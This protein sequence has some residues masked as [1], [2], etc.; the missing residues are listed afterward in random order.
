MQLGVG[1]VHKASIGVDG[2]GTNNTDYVYAGCAGA[3]VPTYTRLA[4]TAIGDGSLLAAADGG[5]FRMTFNVPLSALASCGI[6]ATT[7]MAPFVGTSQAGP[8]ENINKDFF[9]GNSVSFAAVNTPPVAVDDT[10]AATGGGAAAPVSVLVNDSD[11]DGDPLVVTAVDTTGTVGSVS[12][13]TDSKSVSYTPPAVV[14]AG[15]TTTFTYTISD[16]NGGSDVATVTVTLSANGEVNTPPVAVDD[17][18]TTG[19]GSPVAINVLLNDSD[20]DG[21]AL[22][23][24]GLTGPLHGSLSAIGGVVTYTPDAGFS[25]TD[26]F[27]YQLS[28]GKG[29]T[30]TAT[31]TVLAPLVVEAP[32]PPVSPSPSVSPTTEPTQE[33]TEQP[34]TEPTVDP[35]PIGGVTSP[36]PA[37]GEEPSVDPS[38]IGEVTSPDPASGEEPTGEPTQAPAE[39]AS[40]VATTLPLTD[41]T[42]Q[43]AALPFTGGHADLLLGL[44]AGLSVIG[45]LLALTG[46]RRSL[47]E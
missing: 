12:I 18:A 21:D 33:P 47:I 1:G 19:Y 7:A 46:R 37:S 2:K 40:P 4:S 44:G 24:S 20:P 8:L 29:G 22:S 38:P 9:L 27:T 39:S 31:V 15:T 3:A 16:G 45:L 25:G 43:P 28:D 13:A 35:S 32:T 26:T 41:T 23:V 11:A 30:D 34:T 6:T 5:F 36:D 42:D 14:A 10:H 17:T